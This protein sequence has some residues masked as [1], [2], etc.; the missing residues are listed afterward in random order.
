M[1]GPATFSSVNS[2]NFQ[3]CQQRAVF[4][5]RAPEKVT[6]V[7]QESL[8]D[9]AQLS[10]NHEE[11]E[12]REHEVALHTSGSVTW[13]HTQLSDSSV[14][15]GPRMGRLMAIALDLQNSEEVAVCD[16]SF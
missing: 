4:N 1:C 3:S 10:W 7:P 2:L 6:Q 16:Y 11:A 14:L 12:D 8:S 13:W 9:L 15:S 5:I